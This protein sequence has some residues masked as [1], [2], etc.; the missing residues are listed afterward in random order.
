MK[1]YIF[2]LLGLFIAVNTINAQDLSNGQQSAGPLKGK[3]FLLDYY[4]QTF[5]ALKKSTENLS[6][7]QLHFKPATDKWS[8]GQCL[9]HIIT[10]EK[11]LF[12]FAKQGM[13]KPATPER[14]TEVKATDEKIIQG[15]NDRSFKAKA[16]EDLT[17]KNQLNNSADALNELQRNRKVIADYL[18]NV[19]EE[20][21]RSHISD[22]PFGPVDAYQSFLFIAGHTSRHTLQIEEVKS[23]KNFPKK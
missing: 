16:T 5:N 14:R 19:K 9:E 3:D 20:D 13:E 6:P 10:T 7:A 12:D 1:R 21:L 8:V 23:D 17:G 11:M 22:S 4:Q 18:A 15:I 2:Q